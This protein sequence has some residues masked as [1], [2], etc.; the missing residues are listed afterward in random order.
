MATAITRSPG[1]TQLPVNC[2]EPISH[3]IETRPVAHDPRD[4]MKLGTSL[5][6]RAEL[7][8]SQTRVLRNLLSSIKNEPMRFGTSI[9][10]LVSGLYQVYQGNYFYGVLAGSVGLKELFNQATDG[11]GSTLH[12][13][14]NDIQAD[15]SIVRTLQEAQGKRYETLNVGLRQIDSGVNGL[16]KKLD[17]LQ[18]ISI[19]GAQE[20]IESKQKAER[21]WTEAKTAFESVHRLYE[22]AKCN[23]KSAM[24]AYERC[25]DLFIAIQNLSKN[26]DP[27]RT[28]ESKVEE[29]YTKS[30]EAFDVCRFGQ[31]QLDLVDKKHAEALDALQKAISIKDEVYEMITVAC[32]RAI[33]LFVFGQEKAV[34]TRE[35]EAKIHAMQ[36]ELQDISDSH[37]QIMV[38][39]REMAG[40]VEKAKQLARYKLDPSDLVVGIGAGVTLASAGG[41]LL[42][43]TGGVL[44]S[45]AWHCKETLSAAAKKVYNFVRGIPTPEPVPMQ[46]DETIQVAMNPVSSG[47]WGWMRGYPSF[48]VGSLKVNLRDA[49]PWDFT[50]DLNDPNYPLEK[51]DQ[52]Q[53]F[54]RMMAKLMNQRQTFPQRQELAKHYKKV[55][56]DLKDIHIRRNT[57]SGEKPAVHGFF[58]RFQASNVLAI[59][60]EQLCDT[61][62]KASPAA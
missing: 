3:Q 46:K 62:I 8:Y 53:I 29:L 41:L 5:L 60:L 50:F 21:R 25:A 11:D 48:T 6:D 28:M 36:K 1:L 18:G 17:E 47:L 57:P 55:I 30:K 15:V 51:S 24:E 14:L 34:I 38:L 32:Q 59:N 16:Y 22:E 33:H 13:M 9:I 26:D 42:P 49:K 44:A 43:L 52:L 56:T 23:M 4:E 61:L 27:S 35:C 58:Q 2:V 37:H 12:R 19:Q 40:D 7:I 10:S 20:L 31:S 54:N 45:Y 39:I